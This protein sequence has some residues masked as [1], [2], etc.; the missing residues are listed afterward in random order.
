MVSK[1]GW[2]HTTLSCTPSKRYLQ[3][4]LRF[5]SALM[6]NFL[7]MLLTHT[8]QKHLDQVALALGQCKQEDFFR[9]LSILQGATVGQHVRHILEF[10][11]C[12]FEAEKKGAICY[13]KRKRDHVTET[14]L[15]KALHKIDLVRQLLSRQT[16]DFPLTVIANY[17]LTDE[18]EVAMP[19]SFFRELS[20]N[21]EH[22]VHH[23]AILR[24]AIEQEFSYIQLPDTFGVACSTI[25]NRA[26]VNT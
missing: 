22:V 4:M 14:D 1:K 8:A 9:P 24:M 7:Q 20:Y 10:F 21:I 3:L 17:S 25:R 16:I 18:K 2:S 26:T 23:M 13:D 6:L 11:L 12:L 5:F 19:S 15:V